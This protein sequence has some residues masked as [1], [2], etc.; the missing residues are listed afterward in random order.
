MA[1]AEEVAI[2][3]AT[4]ATLLLST[5][6][7]TLGFGSD[8]CN[9]SP[10][11]WSGVQEL[12]NASY[13]REECLRSHARWCG[14]ARGYHASRRGRQTPGTG[15]S[16]SLRER[17]RAAGVPDIQACRRAWLRR[18]NPG[19]SGSVPLGRR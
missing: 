11:A 8:S 1:A 15:V 6:D 17:C 18:R 14:F 16:D 10:H 13:F 19:R 7:E 3:A 5:P 12:P 2:L 9:L 4:S